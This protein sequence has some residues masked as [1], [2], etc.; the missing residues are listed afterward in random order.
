Q[1]YS[2]PAPDGKL[3]AERDPQPR[4]DTNCCRDISATS[5]L[6]PA[7]AGSLGLDLESAIAVTLMTCHPVK[8]PTGTYGPIKIQGQNYGALLLGRS[9]A[10]IMGLF[11]L[12]GVID[13]DYTGEIQ[14]M[15]HTLFPPIHIR[16]GQKIAQLIPLPQITKGLEPCNS[17]PRGDQGFG[18][19][20]IALLTMDLHT[21]PKKKVKV[22][23]AGRSITLWGLLDTGADTSIVSPKCW[24]SDWPSQPTTHTVTGVGGFTLAKKTPLVTIDIG[25]QHLAAVLCIVELPPTVQCLIGRDI[26]AQ[27]GVVL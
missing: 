22:S 25:G 21:R 13:A 27:M 26:L 2:L 12:P 1:Y 18:S 6:Q 8:I 24:P 20:G 17:Q 11:I 23:Y 3:P 4:S 5:C 19:S 16:K 7:T 9:S 14:I 15:A 10:S